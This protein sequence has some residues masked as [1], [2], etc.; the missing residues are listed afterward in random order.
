M[1][2]DDMTRLCGEIV[3]MRSRRGQLLE[4][5]AAGSNDLRRSMS[6]LCRHFDS[7]RATM[8]R[9]TRADRGAFLHTLRNHVNQHL[10]ETRSDLTGVRRTWAGR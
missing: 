8:A 5:L 3:S 6:D 9:E 2:A 1:I 4:E 10:R 7:D